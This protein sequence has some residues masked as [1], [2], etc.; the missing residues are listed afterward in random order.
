MISRTSKSINSY[1]Y[2]N[3]G[4]EKGLNLDTINIEDYPI[5]FTFNVQS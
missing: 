5:A 3:K 1:K 4:L 2:L